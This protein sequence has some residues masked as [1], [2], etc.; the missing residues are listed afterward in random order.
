M[1]VCLDGRSAEGHAASI[2]RT[3]E[4]TMPSSGLDDLHP[5]VGWHHHEPLVAS[6]THQLPNVGFSRESE[7][8]ESLSGNHL[9]PTAMQRRL[10][11]GF[12]F[13]QHS[14][15]RN[16]RDV[17]NL[18]QM[19][20]GI[21]IE[22]LPALLHVPH[23]TSTRTEKHVFDK[24]LRN[25]PPAPLSQYK[26][27]STVWLVLMLSGYALTKARRAEHKDPQEEPHTCGR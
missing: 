14:I 2:K 21:H 19:H 8:V 10:L 18:Q 23:S 3:A 16:V 25:E 7:S 15:A 12:G 5:I 6:H 27:S 9:Q 26:Y 13:M 11:I 24:A 20:E 22:L 17:P 4:P 1:Q